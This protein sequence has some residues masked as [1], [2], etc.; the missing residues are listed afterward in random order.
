ME[1][2]KAGLFSLPFFHSAFQLSTISLIMSNQLLDN[3]IASIEA[4]ESVALVTVVEASGSYA[5]AV[6]RRALVRLN[7]APEG[8]LG[9]EQLETRVLADADQC[10]SARRPQ[11]LTYETADGRVRLFVEVQRRPATLLIVGAG[12]VALPLAQLGKMIDF[13]VVV[14]DDRPSFANKQRFPMADHVLAQPLRETLRR[15]PIDE[16]T[17]IV[18]VTRGHRHDVDCLLEVID[19]SARYIGMIGSKRRIRGV[20][21]LLAHEKGIDPA[22][23]DKVYAPIGLDL[24]AESPAEIGISIIAEIINRY[25]G[26]RATSLAD[27]LKADRRLSLH[28]ARVN[29]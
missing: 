4:R 26:G 10:L 12:H 18:L 1:E 24:G 28:P 15:W 5:A 21:E 29:K 17:Y 11:M 16:D 25:R 14:L 13:E 7:K 19:S 27:A 3:L 8:A 22:K 23:F 6:G 2:W 20:F 9:L